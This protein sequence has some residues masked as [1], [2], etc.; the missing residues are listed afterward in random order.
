MALEIKVQNFKYVIVY[1]YRNSNIMVGQNALQ[2]AP[3]SYTVL[4]YTN[5]PIISCRSPDGAHFQH[6]PPSPWL[7]HRPTV[8]SQSKSCVS[9][10]SDPGP[11]RPQCDAV[12][13]CLGNKNPSAKCCYENRENSLSPSLSLVFKFLS[14]VPPVFVRMEIGS[15]RTG[16]CPK[17][18][19][20]IYQEWFNLVDSGEICYPLF[21]SQIFD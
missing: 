2:K 10:H 18:H 11:T 3:A 17:E 6:P 4:Y 16:V 1:R 5:G 7:S 14:E 21:L 12:C 15:G 9:L 20:K 13:H 19:Q 8:K